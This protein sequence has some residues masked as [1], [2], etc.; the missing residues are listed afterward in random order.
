MVPGTPLSSTWVC[1][2][3]QPCQETHQDNDCKIFRR[4]RN[5]LK[6]H[7]EGRAGGEFHFA[8]DPDDVP[9]RTFIYQTDC[10]L[11]FWQW[12]RPYV[13]NT[14]GSFPKWKP[15]LLSVKSMYWAGECGGG[16][17]IFFFFSWKS[18]E[19]IRTYTSFQNQSCLFK[20]LLK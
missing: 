16:G 5:I 17:A 3:S 19:T 20:I 2:L 8:T 6:S 9:E 11:I 12:K 14:E 18:K 4:G 1:G 15:T 7:S 10:L 13:G